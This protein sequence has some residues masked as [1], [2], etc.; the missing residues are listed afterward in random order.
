MRS[1]GGGSRVWGRNGGYV[2]VGRVRFRPLWSRHKGKLDKNA[3]FDD[4]QAV[5]L[6]PPAGSD[7]LCTRLEPNS[8]RPG[9]FCLL[10]DDGR[11]LGRH[12]HIDNRGG[13]R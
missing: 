2:S 5:F 8:L 13:F 9:R 3:S 11:C 7:V 10:Y 4:V 6:C 12:D 1:T